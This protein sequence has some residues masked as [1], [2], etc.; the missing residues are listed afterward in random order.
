MDKLDEISNAPILFQSITE[1]Q[2]LQQR[3]SQHIQQLEKQI[4]AQE[5][6]PN[7]MSEMLISALRS[8]LLTRQRMLH[9]LNHFEL[10][11]QQRLSA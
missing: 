4:S 7:E 11:D 9:Q 3:I 2:L 1:L 6:N 5:S 10:E 8:L